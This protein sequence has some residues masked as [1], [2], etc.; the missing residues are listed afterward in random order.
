VLKLRALTANGD[1]DAYWTWHP[2]QERRQVHD[3]R[4]AQPAKIR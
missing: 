2:A 4:Y 3:S 1:F